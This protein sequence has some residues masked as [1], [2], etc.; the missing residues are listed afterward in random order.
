M[1]GLFPANI[2]KKSNAC[3]CCVRLAWRAFLTAILLL[4]LG[5][6]NYALARKQKSAVFGSICDA[7][8]CVVMNARIW[9]TNA[10][11][12]F[13]HESTTN[14]DG[15]FVLLDLDPGT[16]SLRAQSA[17]FAVVEVTGLALRAKS[18]RGLRLRLRASATAAPSG[19]QLFGHP[20]RLPSREKE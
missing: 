12:G 4:V 6:G 14:K 19:P 16:Y 18:S 9:L 7:S 1:T 13:R 11:T 2:A 17:G 15:H 10:S 8:G 5:S 20:C 3:Q